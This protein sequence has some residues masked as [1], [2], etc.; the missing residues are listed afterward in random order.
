MQPV[1]MILTSHAQLG[2]TGEPTGL[3]AE[4][5]TTPCGG[6]VARQINTSRSP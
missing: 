2:N 6:R 3:W 5:L 4:E 1:L